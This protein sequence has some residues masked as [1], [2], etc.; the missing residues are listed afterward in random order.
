MMYVHSIKI[1]S[2][3]FSIE[4]EANFISA[5][6]YMSHYSRTDCTSKFINKT[7]IYFHFSRP[8]S[9][10]MKRGQ[11]KMVWKFLLDYYALVV[12]NQPNQ[13]TPMYLLLSFSLL[14]FIWEMFTESQFILC[15]P[16]TYTSLALRS[17]KIQTPNLRTIQVGHKHG[18]NFL[19]ISLQK[20]H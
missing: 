2:H 3:S 6:L 7:L 4:V 17:F 10:S 18:P 16:H 11:G 19:L 12:K 13:P 1:F 20:G 15:L 8:Q 14:P 5:P 9:Q